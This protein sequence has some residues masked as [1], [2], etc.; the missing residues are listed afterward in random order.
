M[1][2]IEILSPNDRLSKTM[3]RL[4]D[5]FQMGVPV[6]WVMDPLDRRGWIALPG[7]WTEALDGL[8]RAGDLEVPLSEVLLPANQR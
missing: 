7:Q 1:L 3:Q 2:C 5:Y 6:C 8:L 4:D